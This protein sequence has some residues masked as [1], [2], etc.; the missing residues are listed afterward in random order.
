MLADTRAIPEL[1][2]SF[3]TRPSSDLRIEA[4]FYGAAGRQRRKGEGRGGEAQCHLLNLHGGPQ[5][6]EKPGPGA[7]VPPVAGA[8]SDAPWLVWGRGGVA[9]PSPENVLQSRMR[10]TSVGALAPSAGTRMADA[11]TGITRHGLPTKKSSVTYR[12]NRRD[13]KPN[14]E[15]PWG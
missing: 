2:H 15:Q 4:A 6:N 5:L 8:G 10:L 12:R 9:P 1:T 13:R 11:E 14:S 3:P 7:A